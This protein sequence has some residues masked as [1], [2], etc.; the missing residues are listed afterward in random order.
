MPRH[1]DPQGSKHITPEKKLG[2]PYLGPWINRIKHCCHA[3]KTF[4]KSVIDDFKK[5]AKDVDL[6]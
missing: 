2:L 4:I 6:S 3:V 1:D 5:Y